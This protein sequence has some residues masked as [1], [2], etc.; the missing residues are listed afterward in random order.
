MPS[1]IVIVRSTSAVTLRYTRNPA[2]P[3]PMMTSA[4]STLTAAMMPR[5]RF[6]VPNSAVISVAS[7]W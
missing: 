6:V 4:S 3:M 5:R 7:E 1:A 2:T